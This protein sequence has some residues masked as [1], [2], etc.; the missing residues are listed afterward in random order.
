MKIRLLTVSHKQPGWVLE[1]CAEYEKR[2]P[3]EWGFQLVEIKPEAR[4]SGAST[5]RVQQGE[6]KRLAAAVPKG[7][8]VVAPAGLGAGQV[9]LLAEDGAGVRTSL[10]I[11]PV[12]AAAAGAVVAT[13]AEAAPAGTTRLVA[14]FRGVA[15]AGEPLVAVGALALGSR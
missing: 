10:V 12:P 14:L 9:E 8:R 4:T 5:E 3:R 7:A 11:A 2:L 15:A 1:G 6:A 13:R